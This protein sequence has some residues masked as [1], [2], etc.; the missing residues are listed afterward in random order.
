MADK[1]YPFQMAYKAIQDH[2]DTLLVQ[3]NF[4]S[5]RLVDDIR[6]Y[7]ACIGKTCSADSS[8]DKQPERN[9]Y[10]IMITEAE[11]R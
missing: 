5:L 3:D 7:I 4:H 9:N 2:N 6:S 1:T 8:V 11:L 10:T